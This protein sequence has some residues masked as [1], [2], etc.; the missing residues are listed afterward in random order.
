MTDEE[1]ETLY[2]F[3]NVKTMIYHQNMRRL[4]E[5]QQY[6]EVQSEVTN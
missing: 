6:W 3:K 4:N 2:S 5:S 1:D